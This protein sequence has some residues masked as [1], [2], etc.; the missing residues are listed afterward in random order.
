MRLAAGF[1]FQPRAHRQ[2]FTNR[3]QQQL[4]EKY[5]INYFKKK[6]KII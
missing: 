3:A 1:V 5:R 2:V 4:H 6:K